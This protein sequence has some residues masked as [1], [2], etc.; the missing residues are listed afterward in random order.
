MTQES[1]GQRRVE[2]ALNLDDNRIGAGPPRYGGRRTGREGSSGG[3]EEHLEQRVV[4]FL[5]IWLEF[6]LHV[7]DKRRRHGRE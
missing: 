6:R 4:H 2:D 3:V 7:D 1:G 5:I